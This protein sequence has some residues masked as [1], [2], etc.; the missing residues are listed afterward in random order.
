MTYI[1]V[2]YHANIY[3]WITKTIFEEIFLEMGIDLGR[4][5]QKLAYC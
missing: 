1:P 2:T 4:K 5:N 3:A